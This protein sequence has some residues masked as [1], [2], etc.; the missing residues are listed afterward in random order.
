MVRLRLF[1][2]AILAKLPFRANL[3]FVVE[4]QVLMVAYLK[5][6]SNMKLA[7]NTRQLNNSKPEGIHVFEKCEFIYFIFCFGGDTNKEVLLCFQYIIHNKNP[8]IQA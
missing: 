5:V 1:S 4:G 6:P 8:E 7:W 2:Y 3:S